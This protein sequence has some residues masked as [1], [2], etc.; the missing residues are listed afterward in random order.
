MPR[1]D[2]LRR[3][4]IGTPLP[5]SAHHEE[6]Y[7]NA[8]ALA[9][10]SSDALSSVA[11]ATQEIVLVLGMGGAAALGYTL[12]ITALI[13]GL[14]LV[15]ASSYRQTIKAYPHGGGSYRVSQ[16]NLG[17]TAGL[18]AGASLS[19]DY[20]LT[21]A[22]SV[23]AGIA[24]L[25]SYVPAL[26]PERVPLCLL[27]VLLVMLAN[28][29]G[30]SSSARFLSVP[31]Y[32]F[33]AAVVTLL[34]AG[35]IKTGL[36]QL[37]PLPVA[38]QQRLLEAA[39]Q[40]SQGLQA[41]GPLLLMRAFSSGCAA[42]TGIEAISDSVAAFRPT[43]WRNARRVLVVMVL[44]LAV[45]FSGISALA[46]QS[47]LVVEDNGPTLLY[48]LGERILGDGPLLFV[49]QLA[50]L[51][52][53]LLAANTA[54]ADFPRLAAFLAQDGFLPRQLTSLGD[55]LVFS[56]G[57]LALS[58]LAGVLLVIVEG[59]VSRLI[60]LYAVGVFISF[61]LSQAG[62][63]MH[64]RKLRDRGWRSRALVNG[65]GA[66][67]TAV[68]GAVLLISKFTQGAWVVVLAIPLLVLMYLRIRTHYD[69]V[70]R[71]LRIVSEGRLT[72]PAPPP[73]GDGTPTVVLVGQLHR[74][75]YEALCF[76]RSVAS[77]LVAVHVDLAGDQGEAFR[78]QWS[79]QLPDVPLEVLPSPYRSLVDPVTRFVGRFEQEHHKDRHSFC[80]VVL[81]VF[82][83][84]HRWENLLH[85]QSTIRLRRALREHGTRVVTTVGFYL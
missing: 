25:T 77:D 42:L 83:T 19:I 46:S 58:A 82:V 74:G 44:M 51:L 9:I 40:G 8:E 73:P 28:L 65:V 43:E 64:W 71:R 7:S 47:G 35:A 84:R 81:P 33:M 66:T 26:A 34:V 27:A 30:V 3:R 60:P 69:H 1:L 55:R 54:Y 76:A 4:R 62:M 80:M 14:M 6:R 53:L 67:I 85:N 49:L 57:I 56:N 17:Q 29:R 45:M 75:S 23:A 50:T 32:L 2:N 41:I 68:V 72:L 22:V 63:V 31:T 48:Q 39:H 16:Q 78:E 13:V 24:A 12:P 70:A 38:E 52:I 5:T 11:Y 18:V 79:R 36:G 59:S 10:L 21:V 15:V 20:V 37:P 61:T